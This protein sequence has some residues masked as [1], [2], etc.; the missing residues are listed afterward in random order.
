MSVKRR[1]LLALSLLMLVFVLASTGCAAEGQPSLTSVPN[2]QMGLQISPTDSPQAVS[3]SLQLLILLTV[4]TLAPAM[5]IMLTAFTR[6]VIVL[7]FVRSALALPQVPPNQ[8][9]TGLALFLTFFI[10]APTWNQ[11]NQ[12]A[13]QPYLNGQINQQ[14]AYDRAS[15]PVREFLFKQTRE[16][17]L[18]LFVHMAD[19]PRPQTRDDI[20]TYVL[21]PA[22]VISELKTAFQMGILIFI[23]FLILDMVIASALM[24]MGMMMLPPSLI[25]MPFKLLLFVMVDGWHL[26]VRSLVSSFG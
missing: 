2:V 26:I 6:I 20:P 3:S 12:D 5:L 16:N 24:S 10:M 14:L 23:P 19:L 21:I 1:K 18:A 4:L 7:S 11:V 13:L 15:V 17:D 22:F 8:V 9:I 25:S